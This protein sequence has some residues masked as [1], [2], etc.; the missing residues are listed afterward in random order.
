MQ[1]YLM[2]P[3]SFFGVE[4]E[5]NPWMRGN[6]GTI[7]QTT[8]VL[9]WHALHRLLI[10]TLHSSVDVLLPQPG[11]PDLVFTANAGL[12]HHNTV[13][14]ARFRHL[15]RQREE[16]HFET[17]FAE[18]G[19]TLKHLPDD[20]TAFEGAGDALFD[21]ADTSLLWAAYG[22]RTD[23][24]VHAHLSRMLDVEVVSLRLVDPH[25]YH[26]DTCFCPLADGRVLWYPAAF[27]AASRALVEQRVPSHRRL[28]V[29]PDDAHSFACNAVAVDGENIVLHHGSPDLVDSL[30]GLGFRSHLTPLSE[31]LKSGGAAKCLTLRL[32]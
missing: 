16:P 5:I 14:P 28:A 32:N 18:H 19:W 27:D 12:V 30:R 6:C 13:I 4:Y 3:P 29:G 8:A 22:F 9:Q 24:A 26:L 25:F 21:T 2:C 23:L 17:W 10:E 20:G 11:L 31:F 15:E 7:V 1:H